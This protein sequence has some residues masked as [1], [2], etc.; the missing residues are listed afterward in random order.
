MSGEATS[1]I[2]LRQAACDE[3]RPWPCFLLFLILLIF[4]GEPV[5]VELV[6]VAAISRG[7]FWFP[8]ALD[9]LACLS[10]LAAKKESKGLTS[11]ISW[12]LG[13]GDHLVFQYKEGRN[14][15]SFVFI[16]TGRSPLV[17][18]G[19]EG[20]KVDEPACSALRFAS[21]RSGSRPRPGRAAR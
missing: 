10:G 2:L 20:A 6:R 19:K 11:Q 15:V 18:A 1:V 9:T 21:Q 3:E 5:A 13:H 4:I 7:D 16:L 14:S 12:E 17:K 8:G